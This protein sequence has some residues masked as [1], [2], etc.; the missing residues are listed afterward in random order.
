MEDSFSFYF[1]G[2]FKLYSL[3]ASSENC[4][5]SAINSSLLPLHFLRTTVCVSALHVM[6]YL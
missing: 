5:A 1:L 6:Y 3:S 2:N 4:C